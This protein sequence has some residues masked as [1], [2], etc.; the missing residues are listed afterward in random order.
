[1]KT[2]KFHLIIKK[3]I[4][5]VDK[6]LKYFIERRH[7]YTSLKSTIYQVIYRKRWLLS[8]LKLYPEQKKTYLKVNK[9]ISKSIYLYYLK[10]KPKVKDL[11]E[12]FNISKTVAY[13]IIK[14]KGDYPTL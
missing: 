3:E 2:D 6:D 8:A 5:Q 4:I 12:S 14:Y 7:Y 11:Q 9:V 10:E 1:M 13:D